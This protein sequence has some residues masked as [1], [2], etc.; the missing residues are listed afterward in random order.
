[1]TRTIIKI[2]VYLLAAVL[3]LA[4]PVAAYAGL[5]YW[6]ASSGLP[7]WDGALT[8]EGLDGLV[9]IVRDEHWRTPSEPTPPAGRGEPPT[10]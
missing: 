3:A 8:A 6:R 4:L 2:A 10:D 7:E 1:M 9:E 5:R